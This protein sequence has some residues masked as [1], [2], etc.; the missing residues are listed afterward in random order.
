MTKIGLSLLSTGLPTPHR[1]AARLRWYPAKTCAKRRATQCLGQPLPCL[2]RRSQGVTNVSRRACPGTGQLP[3]KAVT[4]IAAVGK[5]A[6]TR[7]SALLPSSARLRAACD[8]SWHV[9]ARGL[10]DLQQSASVSVVTTRRAQRVVDLPVLVGGVTGLTAVVI[11][12]GIA[13][14][15]LTTSTR[16][17]AAAVVAGITFG[18]ALIGGFLAAPYVGRRH[19]SCA[20]APAHDEEPSR[21]R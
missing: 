20:D 13:V 4:A 7:S 8:H 18:G 5:L 1:L 2:E 21:S 12:V 17:S 19:E 3:T 14:A 10:H 11:L 6:L 15:R 9:S 16:H